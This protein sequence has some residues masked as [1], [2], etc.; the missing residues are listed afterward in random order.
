MYLYNWNILLYTWNIVSQLYF[1][2][3]HIYIYIYFF[4]FKE[5][6]TPQVLCIDYCFSVT[7]ASPTLCDPMDCNMPGVPVFHYLPELAQANVHWVSDAIQPSSIAPFS[8]HSQS[9]PAPGSLTVSQLI[10]SGGQSIG[11]SA[12]VLP[13][14]SQGWFPLGLTGLISL[15]CEELSKVFSSTTIQKNQFFGTQ[16]SIWSNSHIYT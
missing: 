2:H 1:N 5:K 3:T 8:S 9:F 14:N 4:F 12:S 11:A 13:M 6:E 15:L 10:A 16:P 7:R